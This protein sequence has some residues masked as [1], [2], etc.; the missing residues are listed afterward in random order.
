M[1]PYYS[2]SKNL[3]Y[4]SASNLPILVND[5][6]NFKVLLMDL[7]LNLIFQIQTIEKIG[8]IPSNILPDWSNFDYIDLLRYYMSFQFTFIMDGYYKAW[9]FGPYK[10]EWLL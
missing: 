3:F 7:D 1:R 5:V 4:H 8:F 6:Y 9:Q 10:A 2:N